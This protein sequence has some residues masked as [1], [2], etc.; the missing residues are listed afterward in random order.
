MQDFVEL[1]FT[2]S[3]SLISKGIRLF[4]WSKFSHV[5]IV[6]P[7]KGYLGAH[8][9]TGVK[10]RP[11]DYDIGP[12]GK[13]QRAFV[14]CT[15]EQAQKVFEFAE[16]Q[17]NKPYDV[18]G[19]LGILFHRDWHNRTDSFF[20][21]ELVAAAFESAGFPLVNPIEKLD[22]V[23]PRDIFYSPRVQLTYFSVPFSKAAGII[24][25]SFSKYEV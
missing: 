17:I 13:T 22:R 8:Y 18:S 14:A 24:N 9:G 3:S 21:S 4:T 16:K 23:T 12:N 7:G 6:V 15:P 10:L 2:T 11:F 5:E 1:R 20:C 25:E 19:C